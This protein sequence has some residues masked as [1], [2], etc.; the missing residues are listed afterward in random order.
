MVGSVR[1]GPHH[2]LFMPRGSARHRCDSL[3]SSHRRTSDHHCSDGVTADQCARRHRS[4]VT[5]P[6]RRTRFRHDCTPH[7]RRALSR[8]RTARSCGQRSAPTELV[9]GDPA[10]VNFLGGFWCPK[11]QAFLRLLTAF[12]SGVE[13]AYARSCRPAWTRRTSTRRF[14]PGSVRAGRSRP[15]TT[16]VMWTSLASARRPIRST[17]RTGAPDRPGVCAERLRFGKQCQT[18]MYQEPLPSKGSWVR[19]GPFRTR[20]PKLQASS[21]GLGVPL[22][23]SCSGT[24]GS[25]GR[26]LPVARTG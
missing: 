26:A 5:Q 2:G 21:R 17:T 18:R 7:T 3:D 9:G 1:T 12:P 19:K 6:G 10:F 24:V 11:E 23:A 13:V 16:G 8:Y 20:R 25:H 14:V 22:S 15:I 4:G